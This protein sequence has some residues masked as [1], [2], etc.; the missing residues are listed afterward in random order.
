MGKGCSG[1]DHHSLINNYGLL[2][3]YPYRSRGRT[4][5]NGVVYFVINAHTSVHNVR[6]KPDLSLS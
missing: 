3:F 1:I 2:V 4:Q 5:R 6:V